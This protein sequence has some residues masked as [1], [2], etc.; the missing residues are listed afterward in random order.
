M[1]N[2]AGRPMGH[3]TSLWVPRKFR[4]ARFTALADTDARTL[5]VTDRNPGTEVHLPA[6]SVYAAVDFEN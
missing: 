5:E 1:I 2:Y 3:P 4:T 6:F